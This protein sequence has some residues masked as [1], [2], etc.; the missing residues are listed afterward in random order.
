MRVQNACDRA[1]VAR[2]YGNYVI[3]MA[4]SQII[5]S[6]SRASG[7]TGPR[8]PLWKRYIKQLPPITTFPNYKTATAQDA[9]GNPPPSCSQ[10]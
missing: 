1:A 5:T 6:D 7:G 4:Q 9:H 10:S 3:E 8:S 2:L